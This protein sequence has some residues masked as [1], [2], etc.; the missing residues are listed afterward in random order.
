MRNF[1]KVLKKVMEVIVGL[2]KDRVEVGDSPDTVNAKI[3]DLRRKILE[4]DAERTEVK[5]RIVEAPR[6]TE[7]DNKRRDAVN[8][9]LK[10]RIKELKSENVEFRDRLTKME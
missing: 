9:K 10:A 5:R 8:A 4:F 2:L 7:E 6:A 1:A 3:P